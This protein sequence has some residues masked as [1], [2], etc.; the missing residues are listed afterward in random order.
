MQNF[1]VLDNKTQNTITTRFSMLVSFKLFP[2]GPKMAF[3]K[4]SPLIKA[5]LKVKWHEITYHIGEASFPPIFLSQNSRFYIH[6]VLR[7]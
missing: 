1:Q 7:I 6:V 2:I 4:F 5:V 3:Q